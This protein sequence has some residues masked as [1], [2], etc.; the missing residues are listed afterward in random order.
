MGIHHDTL[1]A[2]RPATRELR[3]QIPD[4]WRAFADLHAAA[5]ADG[6]L[7][8]V[9]KELC[10]LA[11]AVTAQCDGCIAS[12]A[13]AAAAAGATPGQVAEVLG[14]ALLMHGGPA[15]VYGPRA[16]AAYTEFV[17]EERAS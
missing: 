14:V 1:H 10:A 13:R 6:E 16:W 9:V 3:R 15:S 17:E 11:I 12:H 2:L 5:M 8:T 7:P 4:T